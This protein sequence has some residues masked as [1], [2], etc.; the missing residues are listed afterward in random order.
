VRDE[1]KGPVI[2]VTGSVGKTTTKEMLADVL[3]T[4]FNVHNRWETTTTRSEFR[5]DS[6]LGAHAHR[7][8]R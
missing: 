5:D 4:T 2:G 3:G 7:A 1:F 8:R 6:S